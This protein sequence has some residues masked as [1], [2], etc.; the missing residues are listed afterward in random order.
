MLELPLFTIDIIKEEPDSTPLENEN[1]LTTFPRL[2]K[3]YKTA[4]RAQFQ[5]DESIFKAEK[6]KIAAQQEKESKDKK[7]KPD[8]KKGGKNVVPNES[9]PEEKKEVYEFED[10]L[11][12]AVKNEKTKYR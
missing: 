3:L 11:K 12:Q 1:D 9:V 6:E 2:E 4:L 5:Y 10:E 8:P 7:A